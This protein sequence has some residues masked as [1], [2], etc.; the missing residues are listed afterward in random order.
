MGADASDSQAKPLA[1]DRSPIGRTSATE[2]DPNTSDKFQFWLGNDVIVNPFDIVDVGQVS[3]LESGDSKTYGLV[4]MLE[5]RTDAPSHLANFIS[6]NFGELAEEPNTPR[7][8]TTVA[9]ANVLSNNADVYMPVGNE[10]DVAFADESGIAEALGIDQMPGADRVPAGLIKMSN[11]VAAVAYID[12]R[13]VLGPESAHINIS[14]I[15]GLATKTSYAMFVIQSILQTAPDPAKIAVVILNVKQGDLL[16]I[17][18]RGPSLSVEQR[19][20]WERMNLEPKP[21]EAGQVHYL[22]PRGLQGRANSYFPPDIASLYAYDLDATA[23]KLDL[24]FTEVSD[25][26][27]TMESIIGDL[28]IG[29]QDARGDL[30]NVHSWGD[31]LWSRPLFDPQDRQTQRWG[32]HHKASVGKFRRHLRRLVQTRQSGIFV[33]SR[34]R[35]EHLLSDEIWKLKGGHAYVVDIAKLTDAEQTLVFG[36]LLRT[37]YALK[38]EESDEERQEPVPDKVIFFVDELNKYAPGGARTSPITEQVLDLAERGRSLGVILISAQQFMSS[39]HNR[40]TGNSATKI[41]GRSG[42]A[43]VLQPDYRFLDDD[44]K[45]NVTRL[46]KGELLLCHAV[47]RQPV[48]VIFPMPAY[49]QQLV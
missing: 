44:L 31:L 49:K 20:L 48:K 5:H 2:R 4:T 45:L 16:H 24:L 19:E 34:S 11:G 40:V 39:V 9:K 17:D 38:A 47:Y 15:S 10:R 22:L 46:G 36:D 18:E 26:S 32:D 8:G 43:E 1:A 13:Y 6:N 29:L 30:A 12:R 27:G 21:F 25:P 37:V 41:I 28:M 3:A 42:S 35:N 14:G 33:D 23:D 7:Q